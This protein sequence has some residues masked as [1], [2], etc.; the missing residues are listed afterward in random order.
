VRSVLALALALLLHA[1]LLF[2]M[3]RHSTKPVETP[4]RRCCG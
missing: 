4:A 1:L 2:G 3:L